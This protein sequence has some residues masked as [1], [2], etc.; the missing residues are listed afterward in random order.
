M[1]LR[2]SDCRSAASWMNAGRC[3]TTT[4]GVPHERYLALYRLVRERDRQLAAAF[5]GFSRSSAVRCLMQLSRLQLLT[6]EDR[7]SFSEDVQR[8]LAGE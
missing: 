6:E 2:W 7:A 5:D 1:R 3:V 8:L 4:R